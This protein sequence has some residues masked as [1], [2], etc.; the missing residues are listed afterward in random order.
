[1]YIKQMYR[2]S[3]EKGSWKEHLNVEIV[4]GR[5]GN[6]LRFRHNKIIAS[7]LRIGFNPEGKWYLHKLRSDFIPS[8]KI[9]MEDDITAS[10]TLPASKLNNL[11]PEYQNKS[12]KL[13]TNCENYLFQR[14]DEAIIRGYD[15]EAEADI[16]RENTFLTNYEPLT[17]EDAKNLYEDAIHFDEYT[18]PVKDLIKNVLESN[19]DTCFVAPS[20]TR[21]VNGVPTNN[22]RYL[23]RN[24]F[25]HENQESYLAETGVRLFRKVAPDKP[26]H[27]P[28]NALLPGR[29]NNP[30]NVEKGIRPLSVFNPIHYQEI[31]ELFMDFIC[32]LTGKSPSTTGA[33]SEGALTKG[34]FNMLVPTTDLNNALLS[35]ILSE[36]QGFS[37]AAGYVGQENRFDHDISILIPEI[38]ARLEPNDRDANKLIQNKCLDK[39]EDF[40]YKGEKILASRLG[41]RINKNFA[42]RCMNR[43]FDEPLAVFNEKMLQPELQDMEI[44]VDGIKNIVEAQQKVALRYFEDGSVEAAIPPLKILLHIM[45][46]GNFEGKDLSNPELR[47][48]FGRNYVLQTEWYSNRLNLKQEKDSAFLK[49]QIQYIE[50]FKANPINQLLIEKMQIKQR[51][52]K[53][54]R[55]LQYVESQEYTRDLIGTIGA[56]SLFMKK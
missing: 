37:S 15:K 9:Q 14:P 31:P 6:A 52:E 56:D 55:R 12:V 41:Y 39:L 25:K 40:E 47:K 51:L 44:F 19:K 53:A 36:Y 34:P 17:K 49:N 48:Q 32:S 30:A 50:N 26:V 20:H 23:Q 43:L 45:A 29:R 10:I 27:F 18:Q 38:W 46:Y 16:V 3:Q 13:V 42:F 28:V 54:K 21:L 33:G 8:Q 7:Y 5:D 24:R 35:C 11:N 1:L 4:N 22:P 2:S